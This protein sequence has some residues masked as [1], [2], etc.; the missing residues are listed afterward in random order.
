MIY[1]ALIQPYFDYCSPLWDICGKHLLDKLQKFQNRAARIIVGLS[2]EINFADVL[3]S[4]G[5]DT[6]ESRRQ[7][8]K[9]VFLYKILND[10]TAPN[11]KQLLIG[12][13]SMPSSYILRSTDTDIGLPKPRREF[14]KKSFKYSGAKLWNSFLEKQKKRNQFL[15]LNKILVGS[16]QGHTSSTFLYSLL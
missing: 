5:W 6:L 12:S 1:N 2:Y 7:S 8:M 13:N 10:Y 14:L 16:T 11:L 3:E 4:L 9:S 15:F